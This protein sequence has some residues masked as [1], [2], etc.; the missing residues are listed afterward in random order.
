MFRLVAWSLWLCDVVLLDYTGSPVLF[1]ISSKMMAGGKM[2]ALEN[3]PDP[4]FP[5]KGRKSA[6][7]LADMYR[8]FEQNLETWRSVVRWMGGGPAETTGICGC[9]LDYY[10]V[11][12]LA[13]CW[14]IILLFACSH[15]EVVPFG[16]GAGEE[17]PGGSSV[18][19]L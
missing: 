19:L 2:M 4:L 8:L 16:L 13:V 18:C 5:E 6:Q 3:P 15:V 14:A 12:C 10:L 9:V 1:Q 11:V 7:Q 17:V